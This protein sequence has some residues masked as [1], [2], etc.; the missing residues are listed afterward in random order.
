[1][2][3]SQ[4]LTGYRFGATYVGSKQTGPSEAFPVL[5]GDMDL[6]GNTAGTL[7]HQIGKYRMKF[8]G[9]VQVLTLLFTL[10]QNNFLILAKC[11]DRSSNDL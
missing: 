5:L 2:S 7:L 11:P 9:Q 3:I 6:Q 4:A 1:L 10:E 8:Q